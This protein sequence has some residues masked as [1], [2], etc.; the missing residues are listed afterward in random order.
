MPNAKHKPSYYR[1]R[2]YDPIPG[3]FLEEDAIRFEGGVDF[4]AYVRNTPTRFADPFGLVKIDPSCNCSGGWGRN[5]L[6]LVVQLAAAGAGRITDIGLRDCILDKLGNNDDSGT[7]VVQCDG[8][9]CDK[10]QKPNKKGEVLAGWAPPF[11][12]TIHLCKAAQGND[13]S[14]ACTMV[15]EFAHTCAK[16]LWPFGEG[17]PNRAENQAFPGLCPK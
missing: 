11:G 15:H 12:N 3:R 6:S 9:K 10:G 13:F 2:Y 4:Y 5:P 1:A 7:G 14:L 8:P 16:K 17:R